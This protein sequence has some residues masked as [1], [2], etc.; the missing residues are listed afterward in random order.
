MKPLIPV[1][2][3]IS[4]TQPALANED[5]NRVIIRTPLSA[6]SLIPALQSARQKEFQ[7]FATKKAALEKMPPGSN[8]D[9]LMR[10]EILRHQGE[11][12]RL[13]MEK[14]AY[15]QK[16]IAEL[17]QKWKT[18]EADWNRE[19]TRHDTTTKN[20]EK[21]PSGPAKDAAISAENAAHRAASKKI[22]SARH[23][24]HEGVIRQANIDALGGTAQTSASVKQTAGT[25][26]GDPAHQ[27]MRSDWDGG[28]GYR[29]TEKVSEILN[30]MGVKG[31]DG[32]RI[33]VSAGVME[34]APDF[35]MTI[36][37]SPG[38]D[39]VGSA[40]HQAQVKTAAAHGE[41][42]VSELGGVQ[43]KPLKDHLATLD[44]AKKAVPGLDAAPEA[45]VG[46]KEGKAMAK[47]AMKAVG[48]A[49]LEPDTV[50][51][52]ASKHGVKN[53]D[54]LMDTLADIKSGRASISDSKEAAKLQAAARELL[55]A[56]KSTSKAK[57]SAHVKQMEAKISEL[58]AAGKGVEAQK[59]RTEM[60]DYVSKSKAASEALGDVGSVK[61]PKGASAKAKETAIRSGGS[62]LSIAGNLLLGTY[63]IYEGYQ[64]AKEEMEEKKAAESKGLFGWS[65][66]KAELAART[67]WHGLGF[68]AA[69]EIGAKAGR[70][71]YEEYEKGIVSGKTPDTWR[72]VMIMKT[73]AVVGG[74]YGFGKSMTYDAVVQAGINAD[75]AAKEGI[76]VGKDLYD[77]INRVRFEKA[78]NEE[79][80]V[81]IYE[82]LIQ[83]GSSTVGAQRA[84]DA[85]RKGDFSEALRLSKILDA[86]QALQLS[87]QSPTTSR[88]ERVMRARKQAERRKQELSS[89]DEPKQELS[90]DEQKLRDLV[91][92]K[93]IACGY[94]PRS[95]LVSH[96]VR[97]Y[98]K[99]GM[100]GLDAA[101]AELVKMQGVFV[102]KFNGTIPMTITVKGC[103]VSGKF[104]QRSVKPGTL[105]TSSEYKA[106]IDGTLDPLSAELTLNFNTTQTVTVRYQDKY[107]Q[108]SYP[109]KVARSKFT[110]SARFTGNG[111][112]GY[113][114][115]WTVLRKAD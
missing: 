9:A 16:A 46:S 54:S 83:K 84:A 40:G 96:L 55:D 57:A 109:P 18:V 42:Y 115:A 27:G 104:F 114:D 53:P 113:A 77:W 10:Q 102:G 3:L 112:R 85:A 28:G 88:R 17:S 19:Y 21:M 15:R 87:A 38:A 105:T 98:E 26:I 100:K 4:L 61:T 36:N 63:G 7:S 110:S 30:E 48:Q 80:A 56:S 32:K 35:G 82:K 103:E 99:D 12:K 69:A 41:T 44:H 2:C 45:L 1:I 43:S 51:K 60:K 89:K 33:K 86:K 58:Q 75:T 67:F 78:S 76:G 64:K 24:V 39:R 11:L 50:H 66:Q 13:S 79:R 74:L 25:R 71:A 95:G 94:P 29:T 97:V 8:R 23:A 52:I 59:M 5:T 72:S 22:A 20:L 31:P 37:A 49:G 65:K 93:L 106:A 14:G 108:K 68:G 101:I 81:Q 91:T 6:I 111:Y 62:K 73:K 107:V 70:E 34:T 92:S 47:G 90:L